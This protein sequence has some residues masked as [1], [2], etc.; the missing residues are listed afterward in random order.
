MLLP[1]GC[2]IL[3]GAV[4]FHP[5]LTALDISHNLGGLFND[6]Q[7]YMAFAYLLQHNHRLCWLDFSH[8]SL[9]RQA[10]P[11]L[12]QALRANS[13]L[14]YLNAEND[15]KEFPAEKFNHTTFFHDIS[16]EQKY[17]LV[18]WKHVREQEMKSD[19]Q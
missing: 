17:L 13:T 2:R 12:R 15:L 16:I 19:K 7:G 8:N 11:A 5:S 18:Q 4:C 10:L 14:T 6:K 3:S 9:P 1:E